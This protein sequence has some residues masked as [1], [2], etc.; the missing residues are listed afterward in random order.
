[1]FL[2]SYCPTYELSISDKAPVQNLPG[3]LWS[4]ERSAWEDALRAP[5]DSKSIG[6]VGGVMLLINNLA[7]P[8]HAVR[9]QM[10]IL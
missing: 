2:N 8:N 6:L 5:A 4:L 10:E 9:L 3:Q 7:G 1:M